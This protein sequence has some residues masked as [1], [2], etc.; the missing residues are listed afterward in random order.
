MPQL[1]PG[2]N[3]K[4]HIALHN[5][6]GDLLITLPGR[7]LQQHP[8]L[9]A[10]LFVG[11]PHGIVVVEIGDGAFGTVLAN[12]LRPHRRRTFWHINH[13]PQ[14]ELLCRPGDAASMIT[15]GGGDKDNI[16]NAGFYF[17]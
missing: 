10:G 1:F 15:I 12:I 4:G 9:L 8:T 5:P 17:R 6:G 3:G 14:A 7:I 2:F 11:Q 13:R 16:L